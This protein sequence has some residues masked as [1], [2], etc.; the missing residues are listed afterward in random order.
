MSDFFFIVDE[1]EINK[2][3][4]FNV[5]AGNVQKP[6]DIIA[7]NTYYIDKSINSQQV[8]EKINNSINEY[9]LKNENFTL[10]ISDA[11]PYMM[12]AAKNLKIIYNTLFH[13]TC[14]AHLA[15]NCA[16]IIKSKYKNVDNLIAS[17]KMLTIKNKTN[18]QI[19]EPIG[20]I[21]SVI[22]TRWNSWLKAAR[23]YYKNLN[24]VKNLMQSINKAG[25]IVENAFI[26]TQQ[27]NL[28]SDLIEIIENYECIIDF[29]EEIEDDKHN[30]KSAYEKIQTLNFKQ[31]PLKIKDYIIQRLEKSDFKNMVQFSIT[32][33]FTPEEYKFIIRCPPSSIAVERSF[34]MLKRMLRSEENFKNE[35]VESYF[36]TYFNTKNCSKDL[37]E[38][39][40]TETK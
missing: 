15:H 27:E 35:N 4:F 17:L 33:K 34:S 40:S 10:L 14:L 2:K 37:M 18:S 5:L 39:D 38:F 12:K 26:A 7:L 36:I 25:I 9:E 16:L 22:V 31:D 13:I 23:F 28:Y 21:P 29:I 1:T 24:K 32:K 11:A 19:F 3:K 8:I 6:K 30:M 20:R